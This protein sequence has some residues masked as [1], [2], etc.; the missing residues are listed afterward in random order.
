V[1]YDNSP[2]GKL[3]HTVPPRRKRGDE[4]TRKEKN[5]SILSHNKPLNMPCIPDFCQIHTHGLIEYLGY[6]SEKEKGRNNGSERMRM[7]REGV[8]TI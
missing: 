2:D 4:K 1:S 7:K 5:M 8:L 3:A 6:K